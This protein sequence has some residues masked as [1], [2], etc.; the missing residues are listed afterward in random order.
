M[1]SIAQATRF[2]LILSVLFV[3]A[4]AHI[5]R[6]Q[7]YNAHMQCVSYGQPIFLVISQITSVISRRTTAICKYSCLQSKRTR[8][9]N[10][11]RCV[12]GMI[13]SDYANEMLFL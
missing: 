2:R 6:V 4:S 12:L 9:D 11:L 3:R 7:T 10:L 5:V 8:Y 1:Y 13:Q